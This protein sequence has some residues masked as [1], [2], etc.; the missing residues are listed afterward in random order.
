[1][2]VLVTVL[3]TLHATIAVEHPQ[4]YHEAYN[5]AMK[6][7]SPL[8]VIIGAKWCPA[9]RQLKTDVLAEV[10]DKGGLKGVEVAFVDVDHDAIA[11]KVRQGKRIPQVVRY[12]QTPNGDW[13]SRRLVG[14]KDRHSLLSFACDNDRNGKKLEASRQE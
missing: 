12:E 13:E 7:G 9:C 2:N 5:K 14:R 4:K 11:S 8:L 6:N 1:M 10:G 3:L